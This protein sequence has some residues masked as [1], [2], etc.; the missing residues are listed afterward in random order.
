MASHSQQLS[1]VNQ[2]QS[3]VEKLS[4]DAFNFFRFLYLLFFL[5]FPCF[6]ISST[7]IVLL[8]YQCGI[9]Y[10]RYQRVSIDSL[11]RV[12]GNTLTLSVVI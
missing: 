8:T 9:L 2:P 10:E 4:I 12:G 3:Q 5:Q 1:S 11:G 6:A 7:F